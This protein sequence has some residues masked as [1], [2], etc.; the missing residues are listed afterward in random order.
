VWRERVRSSSM[1]N[2]YQRAW[3][4][5]RASFFRGNFDNPYRRGTLLSKEWERGW[6]AGYFENLAQ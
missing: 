6:N 2:N 4:E 5:G 3:G 1:E